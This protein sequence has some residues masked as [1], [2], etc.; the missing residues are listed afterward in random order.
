MILKWLPAPFPDHPRPDGPR[1]GGV[2]SGPVRDR[3]RS[4]GAPGVLGIVL[5]GL[6]QTV[7]KTNLDETCFLIGRADL[8][9]SKDTERQATV[10][11]SQDTITIRDFS[12][13]VYPTDTRNHESDVGPFGFTVSQHNHTSGNKD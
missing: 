4:S 12:G 5:G 13:S 6:P 3:V 8:S 11:F 2:H 7:A 1:S 10:D 9:A